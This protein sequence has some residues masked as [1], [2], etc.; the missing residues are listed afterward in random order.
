MTE[1]LEL[2]AA[3]EPRL[4]Q[5]LSMRQTVFY[6]LDR[7]MSMADVMSR[8]EKHINPW[9]DLACSRLNPSISYVFNTYGPKI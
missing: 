5:R 6:K 4:L 2:L 7:N 1:H 9:P 8:L 3:E